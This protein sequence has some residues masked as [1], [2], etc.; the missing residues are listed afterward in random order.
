MKVFSSIY[1]FSSD[2][3]SIITIGTFDGVHLGHRLIF[4]RLNEIA[5]KKNKDSTLLTFSPHPRHV[6]YPDDQDMKLLNTL[7]E[8]KTLLEEL[9]IDNLIV[10][11]FTK[12]FSR[13]KSSNFIRDILVDKFKVHTLIVGYD[14]HFGRNREGSF[15]ELISL[16]KLY[17]FNIE[18]I[19]SQNYEDVAVSSTKIRQLIKKGDIEKANNYLG[20]AYFIN[21][22][23]ITGNRIGNSLG[24]PTAN[25][26]IKNRWKLLPI[27]GVYAVKVKLG[28]NLFNGMM[29][30]GKNPTVDGENKSLEVNIFNF[31]SDI[32]GK[33]VK[34]NF[35]KRVRD[36]KKFKSIHALQRQLEIDKK[37]VQQ[38]LR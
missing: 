23:V 27:D 33:K 34:I 21:G 4:S 22:E 3:K 15:D 12:K 20:Q 18:I 9:G 31:S 5:K 28:R 11:K 25:I 13:I 14:H 16:A 24:F 32:Y 29:N 8:K 7:D 35:V 6:L 37:K 1:D 19:T 30:I 10:H 2:K 36:E 26:L 17:D 38:I